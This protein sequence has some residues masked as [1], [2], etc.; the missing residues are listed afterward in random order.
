[1]Y[2]GYSHSTP[3]RVMKLCLIYCSVAVESN[4]APPGIHHLERLPRVRGSVGMEVGGGKCWEMHSI[5]EV[6][7]HA[8]P[9][10]VM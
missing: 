6:V 2:K 1:M 3:T 5:H 8:E 7:V 4:L 10:L 9:G